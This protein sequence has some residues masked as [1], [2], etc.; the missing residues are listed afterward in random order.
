MPRLLIELPADEPERA[1]RFWQELLETR[2]ES[3]RPEE[4]RGWQT[5]YEGIVFGCTSAA[6]APATASRSPTSRSPTSL[7]PSNEC[8]RARREIVHPGERWVICRD[9]EGTPFGLDGSPQGVIT[10]V[11]SVR[12]LAVGVNTRLRR[13]S[14]PIARTW[15]EYLVLPYI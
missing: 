4:G 7:P 5:E 14:G 2:L 11:T 8:A 6:R 9:S 3:R 1:R 13:I 10:A 15:R 12:V